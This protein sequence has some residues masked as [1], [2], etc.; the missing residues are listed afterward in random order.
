MDDAALLSFEHQLQLA[1]VLGEHS[2][3]VDMQG[4]VFTFD[5]ER[6]RIECS[7]FHFLGSAAPVPGTW[8]WSW[9]NQSG[10]PETVSALATSVRA[11]GIEHHIEELSAAEIPFEAFPIDQPEPH[12][13]ASLQTEAAKA[14]TGRWTSYMGTSGASGARLAFLVEH[15]DFQLPPP[16][17]PRVMYTLTEGLAN[18][19]LHDHR[20]AA[21]SYLSQRGLH[22]TFSPDY[23]QLIVD[24]AILYGTI[25]FDEHGRTTSFDMKKMSADR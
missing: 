7:N 8:L 4:G 19:I 20:R 2:W 11:F 16:E 23:R 17:G 25:E 14:V 21:S 10:F 1:D 15:Q 22:S 18:L 5:T 13:V 6:G 12:Q 24:S 3:G 9:A